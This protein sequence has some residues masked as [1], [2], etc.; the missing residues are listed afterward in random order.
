[1]KVLKYIGYA[2]LGFVLLVMGFL[3]YITVNDYRPQPVEVLMPI[4]MA[5][6]GSMVSDTQFTLIDWNIGYA[7]LGANMDFFYDGGK[8]VRDTKESTE[9]NLDA[10]LDFIRTGDSIS[11]WM[12]Q[13]VDVNAKRSY[14]INQEAELTNALKGYSGVFATNYLVPFVPIPISEPM[15]EVHAGMMTFSQFP[16]KEALRYAYPL[17]AR[18]PDRLFLLDRCFVLSRYQLSNGHDLCIINTHNSAYVF[19]SVL[20]VKELQILKKVML[21]EYQKG[22][23]VVAGGDWNQNPPHYMPENNYHGHHFVSSQVKMGA[24]FLPDGWQ[25]VF[26]NSAPTNR[27]NDQA[28]EKGINGTTCLDYFVL[29]P[30][31]KADG[32]QV[33]DLNFAHS[34]HNPVF[35]KFSLR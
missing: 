11:F 17:I 23:Y 1:M 32:V 12:I 13:E 21:D 10:I 8:R 4:G 15:G 27:N 6:S 16:H 2:I 26:D 20:R 30:N 28:Y 35:L 34:D 18:W 5:N 19:D 29:S 25:W 22:N 24:D 33:V 14:G 3:L 31:L 9:R 7:G